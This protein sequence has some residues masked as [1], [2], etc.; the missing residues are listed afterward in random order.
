MQKAAREAKQHTRWTKPSQAYEDALMGF[1][2]GLLDGVG[3][4][5]FLEEAQGLADEVAWYGAVN[6]LT[7]A[8]LKYGS[9]G[10]PDLYQGNELMDLSLVDPDNRRPVDYAVRARCLDELESLATGSELRERVRSL[11]ETPHDG[12]AKLWVIW[13]LLS[14][15]R[16]NPLLFR[17]GSYRGLAGSGAGAEHVLAF[18]R[19]H[20]NDALVIVAARLPRLLA[21]QGGGA[22]ALPTGALWRD[23]L[24]AMDGWSEGAAFENV[25][26]GATLRVKNGAIPMGEALADFP[27]AALLHR[28]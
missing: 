7:L 20:G 15:R 28:P 8:L 10:V 13:R 22:L 17:N 19:R 21:E 9:P 27:G 18:E 5:S 23:T 12:R 25:L 3:D 14:L 1:I 26:T 24:V 11:L 6:S 2:G 4:N 16:E